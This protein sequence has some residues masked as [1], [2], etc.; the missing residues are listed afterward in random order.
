MKMI[1]NKPK[2]ETG[3]D[4]LALLAEL[5]VP[6]R[7]LR[8]HELVLE[9][10][11]EL[12]DALAR[13]LGARFDAGEIQIGAALHDVGKLVHPSELRGPGHAHEQ[14][15]Q[16]LLIERRVPEHLA[17]F[18]ITHASWDQASLALEDLL[19]ALADKL[20]K[21]KRVAALEGRVIELLAHQLEQPRWRVFELADHIFEGVAA[22]ADDRL[23]RSVEL[24]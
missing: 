9:A 23:R 12:T 1:P 13:R 20:W 14:A 21:G 22:G 8:H 4:A 15:G 5:E 2:L 17:R 16:A 24:G 11:I 6:A 3:A 7:L 10:A 19:V 18:C